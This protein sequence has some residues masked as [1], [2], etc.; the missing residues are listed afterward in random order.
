MLSEAT[1]NVSFSTPLFTDSTQNQ[2]GSVWLGGRCCHVSRRSVA[3][4]IEIP[5]EL[6]E[7]AWEVRRLV[8][9]WHAAN[10]EEPVTSSL[11]QIR[12]DRHHTNKLWNRRPKLGAS[13]GLLLTV[14]IVDL[15]HEHREPRYLLR[16]CDYLISQPSLLGNI[17]EVCSSQFILYLLLLKRTE[18]D[19]LCDHDFSVSVKHYRPVAECCEMQTEFV[20]CRGHVT[21]PLVCAKRYCWKTQK[22]SSREIELQSCASVY[23]DGMICL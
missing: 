19:L 18:Y 22:K 13:E 3:D 12:G 5:G 10:T 17:T 20:A 15:K 9:A 11:G 16:R 21:H 14:Y 4:Q 7:S 23:K 8:P 1:K 2:K 6:G